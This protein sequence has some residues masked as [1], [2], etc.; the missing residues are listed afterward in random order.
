MSAW[1]CCSGGEPTAA[2]LGTAQ[3]A[4]HSQQLCQQQ[5]ALWTVFC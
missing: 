1:A 5:V 2:A 3:L 4:N